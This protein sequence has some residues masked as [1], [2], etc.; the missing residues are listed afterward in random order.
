MPQGSLYLIS[1]PSGAG[2]TSLVKAL[3]NGAKQCAPG[4]GLCVSVSH[5]TRPIRPGEQDGVNYHF[6]NRD[7]F[8]AMVAAGEFLEHAEVFGNFYGTSKAWVRERL[9][10]GWDVILEID[11]QGAAQI[12][13]LLPES[14]GIFIL[15]PSRDCL[16]Q[17]L[18]GRG[19]DRP[20]VIAE[21]MAKAVNEM[22]HYPQADYLV[23][24]DVFEAALADLHAIFR[25]NQLRRS[26]QE[27]RNS[28]LLAAL[29]A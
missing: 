4:E 22:S 11:W 17:R 28:A 8:K 1:A 25:A 6:V 5:T 24:N 12:K 21:R 14:V 3:L 26:V 27:Q 2:K 18:T 9:A 10:Q 29:L 15:P 7:T 19:T 13:K 23:I 20:E 16:E